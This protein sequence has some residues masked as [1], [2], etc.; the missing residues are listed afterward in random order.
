MGSESCPVQ[1][2]IRCSRLSTA[3]GRSD[4]ELLAC[5]LFL[6]QDYFESSYP[7][8]YPEFQ[9][10]LKATSAKECF[11]LER[12]GSQPLRSRGCWHSASNFV[13]PR[14]QKGS[15]SELTL[16]PRCQQHSS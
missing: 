16:R 8:A 11:D 13:H 15:N 2:Q 9:A 5:S 1:I 12:F 10:G 4:S 6:E 7:K 3:G 14:F